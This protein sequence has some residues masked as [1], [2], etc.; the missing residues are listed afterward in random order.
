MYRMI[1]YEFPRVN[2]FYNR[3]TVG[4]GFTIKFKKKKNTLEKFPPETPF[5]IGPWTFPIPA[6]VKK[7]KPTGSKTRLLFS[8]LS[9]NFGVTMQI[10]RH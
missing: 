2:R 3:T 7:K 6:G 1:S 4:G 8:G 9:K 10:V 5:S